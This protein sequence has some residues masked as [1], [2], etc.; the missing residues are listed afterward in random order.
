MKPTANYSI[1]KIKEKSLNN[2]SDQNTQQLT[3][4]KFDEFIQRLN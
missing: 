4:E 1:G 2:S 3:Q